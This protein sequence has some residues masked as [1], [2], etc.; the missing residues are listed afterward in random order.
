M[1]EPDP[2]DGRESTLCEL[3]VSNG[4]CATIEPASARQLFIIS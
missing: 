3:L 2:A 1:H 4:L